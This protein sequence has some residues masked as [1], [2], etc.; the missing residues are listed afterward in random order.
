MCVDRWRRIKAEEVVRF[1]GRCQDCGEAFHPDVF[2]FH[3]LDPAEKEF[4]WTKLRLF[5]SDRRQRELAKCVMLCANCHRMRHVA[6]EEAA[7]GEI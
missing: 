7:L 1:G 4:G 2:E 6:D 3:H 5:S